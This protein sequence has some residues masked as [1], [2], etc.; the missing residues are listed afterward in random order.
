MA[1]KDIIHFI[2]KR[3]GLQIFLGF[4]FFFCVLF[5]II[6]VEKY[7]ERSDERNDKEMIEIANKCK[8]DAL[9]CDFVSAHEKLNAL[10]S[11]RDG[12]NGSNY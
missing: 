10:E 11:D 5:F 2:D 1:I 12:A 3:E 8:A 7:D 6:C 9:A 4:S